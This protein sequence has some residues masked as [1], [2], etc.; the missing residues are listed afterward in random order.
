MALV[1]DAQSYSGRLQVPVLRAT[2]EMRC[3]AVVANSIGSRIDGSSFSGLL[4]RV[5][6]GHIR[7]GS[8]GYGR[9]K[10]LGSGSS[11]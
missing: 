9:I 7:I 1:P 8:E 4:T 3:Q 5:E 10:S 6:I 2:A 11:R